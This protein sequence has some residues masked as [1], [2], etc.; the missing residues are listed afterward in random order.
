MHDILGR[1][2][3]YV[4]QAYKYTTAFPREGVQRYEYA[5]RKYE[6][7]KIEFIIILNFEIEVFEMGS[8]SFSPLLLTI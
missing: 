2:E 6:K 5:P 4:D 8:L 3:A 1:Y 7:R